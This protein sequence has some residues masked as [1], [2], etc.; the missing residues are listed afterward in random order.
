MVFICSCQMFVRGC[1]HGAF[2]RNFYFLI[3]LNLPYC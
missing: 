3:N 2:D 1:I